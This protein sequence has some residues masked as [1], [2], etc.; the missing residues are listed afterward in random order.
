LLE[1]AI[2]AA[3]ALAQKSPIAPKQRGRLVR[4]EL[5]RWGMPGAWR[6]A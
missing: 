4:I 1:Q 3:Q 6:S 2:D 5:E